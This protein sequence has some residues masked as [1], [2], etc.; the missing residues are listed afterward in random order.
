LGLLDIV[1]HMAVANCHHRDWVLEDDLSWQLQT[2]FRGEANEGD[3][4]LM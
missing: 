1:F 4:V 2:A 3:F